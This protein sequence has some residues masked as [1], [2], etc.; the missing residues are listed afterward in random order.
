LICQL[1]CGANQSDLIV[2][3]DLERDV[4]EERPAGDDFESCE[5]VSIA[6]SAQCSLVQRL[7]QLLALNSSTSTQRQS[8]SNSGR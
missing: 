4:V 2:A 7:A 5:T 1:H 8:A 6:E 3:I